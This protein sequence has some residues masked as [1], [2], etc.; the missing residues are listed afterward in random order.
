MPGRKTS[1]GRASPASSSPD[2]VVAP[3]KPDATTRS[4]RSHSRFPRRPLFYFLP[5]ERFVNVRRRP[6]I[7]GPISSSRFLQS[8]D[9]SG[10]ALD[11]G[12]SLGAWLVRSSSSGVVGTARTRSSQGVRCNLNSPARWP[13]VVVFQPRWPTCPRP[14]AI[15]CPT[16]C[17]ITLLHRREAE[18]SGRTIRSVTTALARSDGRQCRKKTP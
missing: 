17:R 7:L 9:S 1:G 12:P 14:G 6:R 10:F 15:R 16:A 4:R 18:N 2:R 5:P 3:G 13:A 11:L 8:R